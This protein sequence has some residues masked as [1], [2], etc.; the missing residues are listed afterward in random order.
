MNIGT[1]K[2]SFPINV[3]ESK[4]TVITPRK[5]TVFEHQILQSIKYLSKTSDW[6]NKCIYELFEKLFMVPSPNNFIA[7]VLFELRRMNVI[8]FEEPD[9]SNNNIAVRDITIT[10]DGL[11]MME[12]GELPSA[13]REEISTDKFDLITNN[14][15]LN[16][17]SAKQISENYRIQHDEFENFFPKDIISDTLMSRSVDWLKKGISKIRNV[18]E[19]SSELSWISQECIIYISDNG[20]IGL[21]CP[22][23]DYEQYLE[24]HRMISQIINDRY[25][26]VGQH[27]V[28]D[29]SIDVTAI[30]NTAY[31]FKSIAGG[32]QFIAQQRGDL[33]IF[34]ANISDRGSYN[35]Y[36]V[37]NSKIEDVQNDQNKLIIYTNKSMPIASGCRF[38]DHKNNLFINNIIVSINGESDS[39]PIA[40]SVKT[41]DKTIDEI[42]K[43][44]QIYY[45]K[46][47]PG[48]ASLFLGKNGKIIKKMMKKYECRIDLNEEG[49]CLITQL[50]NKHTHDLLEYISFEPKVGDTY[51]GIITK[52][53]EYGAYIEISPVLSGFIQKNEL[54]WD[55][56]EINSFIK[57]DDRHKV[58]LMSVKK[59]KYRFS[60]KELVTPPK[61]EI[62]IS[63]ENSLKDLTENKNKDE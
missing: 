49:R 59:N 37:C 60:I 20:V 38:I 24:G 62:K 18:E 1:V 47:D 51:E 25:K 53:E 10:K 22:N 42:L 12:K 26:Q 40:Y 7:P 4:V 2:I 41:L 63:S 13:E 56:I 45:L 21:D 3:Y 50:S 11:E 8:N 61:K 35:V 6:N 52:V 28:D 58:K 55:E 17:A 43:K 23:K 15:L 31:N 46:I 32:M 19:S 44:L 39:F 27:S 16:N 33:A 54:S 29:N 36:V 30:N 5:P 57:A 34:D 14:V 48:K 9:I